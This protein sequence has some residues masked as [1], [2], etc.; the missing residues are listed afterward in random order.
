MIEQ[1]RK[2]FTICKWTVG[3]VFLLFMAA[4]AGSWYLSSKRRPIVMEELKNLVLV[5][6]DSLY[7]LQLSTVNTNYL[8]GNA[9]LLDVRIL[10][11]TN[12]YNKLVKLKRAPNNI[13]EIRVDKLT[14][15]SFHPLRLFMDKKM[16]I[17][18]L[19]FEHPSIVMINKQLEFNENKPPR[20]NRSPYNY[21]SK[22]F[23]EV[24]VHSIDFKDVSLKYIS[25][26]GPV[27]ET[28]SLKN[29]NISLKDW[30]ID[31]HSATDPSRLYLLKDVLINLNDYHYAT[32]DS[33]YHIEVSEL[34]FKAST[35]RLN[36]KKFALAP[37]Y[38]EMDFGHVAGYAKERF[39]IKMTDISLNGI[40]LP[41]YVKK[42]E[43]VANEMN[44]NYGSV[45]VFNNNELRGRG[46]MRMG[47]FPHQLLQSVKAPL[48]VK[49]LKLNSVD[50]SYAEYD[51]ESK[52]KGKITFEN[53][54]GT[55]LNVTNEAKAKAKDHTMLAG[56]DSYMMGK[57]KLHVDFKFDLNARDGA[58]SYS[59]QLTDMHGSALN[60]ITKPL[61]MVKVKSGEVKKLAFNIVANDNRA[62]GK[63]N[64]AYNDLSIGLL[65]KVEGKDRLVKQGLISM[66]ANALVIHPD[67]PN[68]KGEFVAAHIDFE[69]DPT[70]S[71][72]TFIWKTLLQ[73]IKYTVGLT[74]E[75]QAEISAQKARFEKM[76]S[77]RD[78]RREVRQK[79]KE[80]EEHKET[81]R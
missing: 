54:S 67:N 60:A 42:Q 65:K 58:F 43:L 40:N 11:D 69:R 79:R 29:I 32:P 23:K 59:G 36:I 81:H 70:N 8:F 78:L 45:S 26:N 61:G 27:P 76:K 13:Y 49:K 73:G 21:I 38:S 31:A 57:G 80:I 6:T 63:M 64:F 72:F 20:P 48:T 9:S 47:K 71:F 24:S 28:D 39:N 2:T 68:T 3:I 34:S 5:G 55:F 53:T 37:R 52:Q 1:T 77:D 17:N 50:I 19:L 18:Q 44:I 66:L 10:P 56:L 62:T 22:I 46:T 33:L 12:I 35:G 14:F 4:D 7:H 15:W 30:L 75:K 51:S 16:D 41:L 74:P 25:K